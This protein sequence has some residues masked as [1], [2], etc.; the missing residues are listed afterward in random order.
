MDH[1]FSELAILPCSEDN[2]LAIVSI[3]QHPHFTKRLQKLSVY[4]DRLTSDIELRHPNLTLARTKRHKWTGT[5]YV[6]RQHQLG[7]K[8]VDLQLL[9]TTI[10]NIGPVL[11]DIEIEIGRVWDTYR[12]IPRG[13]K[14]LVSLFRYLIGRDNY[15]NE[16]VD[17]VLHALELSGLYPRKLSILLRTW[18][19]ELYHIQDASRVISTARHVFAGLKH[20]HIHFYWQDHEP[21][22]ADDVA[23]VTGIFESMPLLES[24]SIDGFMT[25]T[26]IWL[27]ETPGCIINRILAGDI[28]TLVTL[29]LSGIFLNGFVLASFLKRNAGLRSVHLCWLRLWFPDGVAN[30]I[31][32]YGSGQSFDAERYFRDA[33]DADDFEAD[34]VRI[35]GVPRECF[36]RRSMIK[37]R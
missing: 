16:G 5:M 14:H 17:L 34:A 26:M 29:R 12:N 33:T 36:R 22:N 23:K 1:Y 7:S 31:A 30:E 24:L 19:K 28:T 11:E 8:G 18:F 32:P 4:T 27:S 21:D 15:N 9:A 35:R 25:S 13:A 10:S 37:A 3:S 20:L 6:A 2:L